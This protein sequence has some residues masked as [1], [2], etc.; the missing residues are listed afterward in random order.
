MGSVPDWL[1]LV[2]AVAGL[3]VGGYA[4]GRASAIARLRTERREQIYEQLLEWSPEIYVT[5]PEIL[6][7]LENFDMQKVNWESAQMDRAVRLLPWVD[8]ATWARSKSPETHQ[9]LLEHLERQLRPTRWKYFAHIRHLARL[10]RRGP[11][12][13]QV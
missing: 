4:G 11:W 1:G 7:H 2:I 9:Q 10:W 6:Y 3:F 5:D 13:W 12:P 8:R